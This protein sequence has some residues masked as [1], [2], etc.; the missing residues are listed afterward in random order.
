MNI[1]V[2]G[3]GGRE[4]ALAWKLAQSPRTHQIFVAPGNAGT[5]NS[6]TG[7]AGSNETDI[8]NV[9]ITELNFPALIRFAKDNKVGLTVVGSEVPLCAGIVDAFQAEKLRIF[10]PNQ[11]AAQIEG[12]KVFCKEILRKGSVPTATHHTFTN[13]ND[14]IQFL[15]EDRD[16][17]IV[18]KA[19]GLAA[20]K[21]VFVC[22]NRSEA[23]DA[24]LRITKNREFGNAGDRIILE[25]RLDGQEASV[26]AITDGT[27]IVT[28]QP[29]QDHKAAYDGDTGPNTGGMGAYSPTPMVDDAM[30][31]WVEEH[32]FVPTVHALNCSAVPFRGVLYAGLM[33]TKQ[34]AKVLEYN[35]RFG[36][37]ECQPLLMRLKTDL[38]D[39]FEATID[40]KL[41][42]LPPLEW[43]DRTAVCVV[44]A[45]RGYPGTY[46][47][48][49][50]IRGLDAAAKVP[51]TKV[52]HA[53]TAL[54]E[55]GTIVSNGGR[56]LGVTGLGGSVSEAKLA[57]Y[58]AVKC[59]RWDGAWCRKDIS[60]K[61][62]LQ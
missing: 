54:S 16:M 36:D 23:I 40:G 35:A 60:D 45:S 61:A 15:N 14:A 49:F 57:A 1:L 56:V 21:G 4:H 52:F 34:G 38:P 44:M 20:G 18:V 11:A 42:Q 3:S 37:P 17:P 30:L 25:E 7:N 48:G 10:G 43:D 33:L 5:A 28:L 8:E 59:I 29:A 51:D 12:S 50:P 26:L 31:H 47:K 2:I 27:T 6:N 24:I 53:G 32:I 55:N 39:I 62:F 13:G 22:D 19:D 46:E 9:P 58:T 41:D